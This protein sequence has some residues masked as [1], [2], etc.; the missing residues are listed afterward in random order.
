MG[1]QNSYTVVLERNTTW[2]NEFQ[3]EPYETSWAREA[4]FFIRALGDGGGAR[5]S[6]QISPDGIHWCNEGSSF[7][8]PV[9]EDSVT[10]CRV[11][12]FGGWLRLT[13]TTEDTPTAPVI[14]YLS[15]KE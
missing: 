6:V 7:E 1:T 11:K 10:F 9:T 15:L 14:V 3:T 13:G 8:V 2:Q 12:H 4:I 5:V